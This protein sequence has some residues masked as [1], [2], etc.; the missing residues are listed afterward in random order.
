MIDISATCRNDLKTGI[1]RVA[2]AL[3]MALIDLPP[4][5][6][7][8]EPVYLSDEGGHWHYRYARRYTLELLGCTNENLE[9]EIADPITGDKI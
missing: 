7:R 5:G 2:R 6:F 3:I 4:P 1:E 9:D 8:V